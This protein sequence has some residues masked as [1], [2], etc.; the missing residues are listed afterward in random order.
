MT[1]DKFNQLVDKHPRPREP[2]YERPFMSRRRFF[3]MTGAGLTAAFLPDR[4]NAQVVKKQG[5]T[6]QNRAKNV[7]F[8]LLQGAISH[9][10]TFDLKMA[11][12]VTPTNFAPATRSGMLFPMGL[13]PKIADQLPNLAVVRTVRSWA[14]VHTL[15]QQWVQ[16]GRNP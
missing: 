4:M 10:D 7:I 15:S 6:T 12:G 2:F 16:I 11:N 13:L 9:T 14:L 3:Q 5:V 8:I 1:R